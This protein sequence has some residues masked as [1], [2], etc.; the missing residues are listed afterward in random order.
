ML[1]TILKLAVVGILSFS[2]TSLVFA[3]HDKSGIIVFADHYESVPSKEVKTITLTLEECDQLAV[4]TAMIIADKKL[5]DKI[6][7]TDNV[8]TMLDFILQYD[9]DL[10]KQD[11]AQAYQFI[12]EF[13]YDAGG[14]TTVPERI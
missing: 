12:L 1:K 3:N 8:T 13:C 14:Q 6:Q 10:S 4:A 9:P 5:S 11:P 2:V 7:L